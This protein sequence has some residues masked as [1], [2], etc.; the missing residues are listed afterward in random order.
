MKQLEVVEITG[1]L[2]SGHH[3]K[4]YVN[5]AD[6]LVYIP[7]QILTTTEFMVV[8]NSVFLEVLRAASLVAISTE[9]LGVSLPDNSTANLVVITSD[10]PPDTGDYVLSWFSDHDWLNV[11][12]HT[13]TGTGIPVINNDLLF[14]N[15][16]LDRP[17][18]DDVIPSD[19]YL[20]QGVGANVI[21]SFANNTGTVLSDLIAKAYL[22]AQTDILATEHNQLFW[23]DRY[24]NV[25][26]LTNQLTH[27]AFIH[28]T[29]CLA[30]T[31]VSTGA[32]L[33][34][35]NV[36]TT[37]LTKLVEFDDMDRDYHW[38]DILQGPNNGL[39]ADMLPAVEFDSMVDLRHAHHWFSIPAMA[40]LGVNPDNGNLTSGGNELGVGIPVDPG[41]ENW[42]W[43]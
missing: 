30:D 8:E 14:V 23:V 9:G 22:Q 7:R 28:V 34:V 5:V 32:A 39:V 21:V 12:S 13:V 31:S 33:Y 24:H 2:G 41:Y 3:D 6:S 38:D 1:T 35:W 10:V 27:N 4:I 29:D 37:T 15:T 36:D 17:A 20:Q 43:A 42:A 26:T 11:G 25:S 19:M 18:A 16:V 40:S